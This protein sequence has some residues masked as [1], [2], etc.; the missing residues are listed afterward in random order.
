[1]VN[2]NDFQI[3]DEKNRDKYSEQKIINPSELDK[4]TT[5]NIFIDENIKS[6]NDN[7]KDYK[8]LNYFYN[9]TEN[10]TTHKKLIYGREKDF[11]VFWS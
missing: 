5:N 1:M 3:T 6:E 2:V 8:I 10:N 11:Y 9:N 4:I 7:E